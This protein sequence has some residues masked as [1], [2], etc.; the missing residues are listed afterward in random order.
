MHLAGLRGIKTIRDFKLKDKRVFLR[1]DL[2]VPLEDGEITDETRITAS[3]PTIK[4]AM[5][6]ECKL[7]I[8]SHLGRPK[9]AEDKEFSM[10]PV[11]KRLSELLKVEVILCE[12]FDEDS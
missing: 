4:Y 8:A 2:N 7:I 3:L 6:Q 12:E 1:L 9:S 11:G 5:E 10:E